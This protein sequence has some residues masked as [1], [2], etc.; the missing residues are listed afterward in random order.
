MTLVSSD[1]HACLRPLYARLRSNPSF[2]RLSS[3][4]QFNELVKAA[5]GVSESKATLMREYNVT[6]QIALLDWLS[7]VKREKPNP[8]REV[9]L[10]K[11]KK[12]DRELI[13]IAVYLSNGIDVRL[14]EADRLRCTQLVKG[15][16]RSRDG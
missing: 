11:V 14:M 9:E 2:A 15:R 8:T 3:S 10:W 13:C 6:T 5:E 4:H 12:S 1:P 16:F 7:D